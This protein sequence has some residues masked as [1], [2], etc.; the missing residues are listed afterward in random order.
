MKVICH[1]WDVYFVMSA[2]P[3]FLNF[4]SHVVKTGIRRNVKFYPITMSKVVL[5]SSTMWLFD[6]IKTVKSSTEHKKIKNILK[7]IQKSL[8]KAPKVTVTFQRSKTHPGFGPSSIQSWFG[9]MWLLVALPHQRKVVWVEIFLN[10][11][12]DL[13]KVVNSELDALSPFDLQNAFESWCRRL[14]QCV[15]S[16]E[17]YSEGMWML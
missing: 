8:S 3:P 1:M 2:A 15:W 4:V 11:L 17:E 16:E 5:A 13:P 6:V 14:E 7:R 10:S 12:Q 9:S